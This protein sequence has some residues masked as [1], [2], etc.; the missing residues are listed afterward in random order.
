MHFTVCNFNHTHTRTQATTELNRFIFAVVG[1]GNSKLW[2]YILRPTYTT[3]ASSFI[4]DLKSG[5]KS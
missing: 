2:I 4:K 5:Q 1:A 3:V